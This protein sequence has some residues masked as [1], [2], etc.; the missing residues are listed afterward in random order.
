MYTCMF[1]SGQ[2]S[3]W[4][5]KQVEGPMRR[6]YWWMFVDIITG[7]YDRFMHISGMQVA[8]KKYS[9]YKFSQ[10]TFVLKY[11]YKLER[12]TSHMV[13]PS[14]K[15]LFKTQFMLDLSSAISLEVLRR[16]LVVEISLM[17]QIV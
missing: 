3:T 17:D 11:Y 10:A 13:H 5:N 9:T 12:L 15:Y 6:R 7:L 2:V 4:C 1:M 14:D 16:G 8:T